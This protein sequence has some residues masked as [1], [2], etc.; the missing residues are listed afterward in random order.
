MNWTGASRFLALFRKRRLDEELEE[1]LRFHLEMETEANLQNGMSPQKARR[2]ARLRLG[3][4]EQVKESCRDT[5]AGLP[6]AGVTV[7]GRSL[8]HSDAR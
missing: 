1:E 4:L 2:M 5:P 8:R 6:L 7:A 3:G